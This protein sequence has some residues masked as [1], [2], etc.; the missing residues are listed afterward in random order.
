MIHPIACLFR[1]AKC[2]SNEIR[3]NRLDSVLAMKK[4]SK[5]RI[6]YSL[7][8]E[9]L[10]MTIKHTEEVGLARVVNRGDS[11]SRPLSNSLNLLPTLFDTTVRQEQPR[12]CQIQVPSALAGLSRLTD[13]SLASG[14]AKRE[15]SRGYVEASQI[16]LLL[17]LSSGTLLTLAFYTSQPRLLAMAVKIELPT[18]DQV[19]LPR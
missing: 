18:I 9:L 3:R 7:Y 10:R 13:Q 8:H 15:S 19:K 12:Q 6:L 1:F 14:V 17:T 11:A 16:A 5:R 4:P 2:L